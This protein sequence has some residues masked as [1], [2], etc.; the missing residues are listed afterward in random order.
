MK[1]KDTKI[2]ILGVLWDKAADTLSIAIPEMSKES[3]N[4]KREILKTLSSIYDQLG[5][6]AP[7]TLRGKCI[8]RDSCDQ[9][10]GWDQP[11]TEDLEKRS[12]KYKRML[13]GNVKIPRTICLLQ[14]PIPHIDLH[15]FGDASNEGTAAVLYAVVKQQYL[16]N[17]GLVASSCLLAKKKTTIPRLELTASHLASNLMDN[18][19]KTLSRFS[20]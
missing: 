6:I 18:A 19:R 7:V 11:L 4:S 5:F 13:H 17:Q 2:K 3:K 15:A 10:L 1:P 16:I 8:Y 20:V 12:K 14:E 9:K